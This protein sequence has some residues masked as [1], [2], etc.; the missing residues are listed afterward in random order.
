MEARRLALTWNPYLRSV[1][2]SVG[3]PVQFGTRSMTSIFEHPVAAI[4]A[5]WKQSQERSVFRILCTRIL[6]P[7]TTWSALRGS[8][9]NPERMFSGSRH[10]G[11]SPSARNLRPSP[12]E[13]RTSGSPLSIPE[14][15][16]DAR[17][18][19]PFQ[20][21]LPESKSRR[22]SNWRR[23]LP[24]MPVRA[25]RSTNQK[26]AEHSAGRTKPASNSNGKTINEQSLSPPPEQPVRR[27]QSKSQ[28]KPES[29]PG[30]SASQLEPPGWR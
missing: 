1:S 27:R 4:S 26:R 11:L 22:Q 29:Q 13:A 18:P 7:D 3:F 10:S 24:A 2:S 8:R 9:Q 6:H 15:R 28:P 20:H 12:R 30:W 17:N 25:V 14:I 23:Q 5:V 21:G 16:F 19:L